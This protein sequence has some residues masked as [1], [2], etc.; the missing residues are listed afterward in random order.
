MN[1]WA[2]HLGQ[3]TMA[4]VALFFFSCQD[5]ISQLGFKNQNSRIDLSYIE[6]PLESSV[7]L[8]D[9]IN[10][11]NYSNSATRLLVGS[12][13]DPAFGSVKTTGFTHLF[14]PTYKLDSF[15]KLDSIAL[16]LRFDYYT[17]GSAGT[18]TQTFSIHELTQQLDFDKAYYSKTP[19]SYNNTPL[20][21]GSFKVG[22]TLFNTQYDK[23]AAERDT[24]VLNVTLPNELG[25]RLID[26]FIEKGATDSLFMKEFFYG[27]A[28][29]P[30]ASNDK[31]VGFDY[32][33]S[34]NAGSLLSRVVVY[35]HTLNGKNTLKEDS[36]QLSLPLSG[37]TYTNIDANRSASADLSALTGYYQ[38]IA[39]PVYR[40]AQ[41]GTGVALKVDFQKFFDFAEQHP[42]ILI[43]SCELAINGIEGADQYRPPSGFMLRVMKEGNR[44][45]NTRYELIYD[46]NGVA[47]SSGI[48]SAD[49]F[50]LASYSSKL[51][52]SLNDVGGYFTV[53][54]DR[55][56]AALLARSG[57]DYT[58]YI[59][60][61]VQQLFNK[62]GADNRYRYYG[63]VPTDPPNSK[64]VNRLLFNKDNLKLK[65][66]YTIPTGIQAD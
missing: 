43:N 34:I 42:K 35:Y 65:I 62:K 49:V 55:G 61:F 54:D 3:L 59:S 6:I 53:L 26:R 19:T 17:Y 18:T 14:P 40:Y 20:G 15:P 12:Y 57:S 52:Q 39:P 24:A 8:Q 5:N 9:S 56:Q 60:M 27:L 29:V 58:T 7:Y 50:E 38:D 32:N 28:I 2:K 51:T 37:V 44:Y 10:T 45:R 1:L 30:G 21:T 63:L 31:V 13:N 66:Y 22:A 23:T 16:Q 25:Q 48:T 4:S 47:V 33:N 36:L 41:N 11:T 64:S 46:A